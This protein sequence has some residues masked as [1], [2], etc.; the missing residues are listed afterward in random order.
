MRFIRV[1]RDAEFGADGLF[2]GGGEETI[3]ELPPNNVKG[4]GSVEGAFLPERLC[5]ANRFVTGGVKP[6]GL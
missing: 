4:R 3:L 1:C 5:W 2:E 6:G